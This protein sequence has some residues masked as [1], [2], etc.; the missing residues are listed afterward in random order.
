LSAANKVANQAGTTNALN[1][2]INT[3]SGLIK[4]TVVDP[5]TGKPVPV[6]GVV[7]EKQNF[8]TGFVPG[9]SQTGRFHMGPAE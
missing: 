3:S 4:G 1:L 6:N 7:L 5:G 9:T 2:T 8:A